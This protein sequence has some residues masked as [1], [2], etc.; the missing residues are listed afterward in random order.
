M[1]IPRPSRR[2]A[3]ATSHR[4]AFT[5]LDLFRTMK[6]RRSHALAL[7]AALSAIAPSAM[8][9]IGYTGRN[10][11]SF[12]GLNAASLSITNQAVTGNYGWIDAADASLGDSHRGRAFRFTL[13]GD[14]WVSLTVQA[15]PRATATSIGGLLPGV[16]VYA[17]LAGIAPFP[18]TQTALASSADHDG[19]DASLAW[20]TAYAHANLGAN[21]DWNATDGSWNATGN[22]QIGGDG[23]LPG[24]FT[25]LSSFQYRL[26][27][28][29]D[30][31]D[32][33]VQLHGALAPGDYTV[34]IGGVDRANKTSVDAGKAYGMSVTLNV[35][36][37]PEPSTWALGGLGAL[38]LL[39]GWNRRSR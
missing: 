24:D 9:H 13:T 33:L 25:Q 29:D 28:S 7:S 39:L 34:F 27:A 14:A 19:S 15:N 26:S 37:V 22:W 18:P 32:G 11:G 21:L 31:R 30:D 5:P 36:P 38:A 16:S 12:T 10:F 1:G 35:S 23:D 4:G 3:R 17:G 6:I 2:A 8:A 20:R